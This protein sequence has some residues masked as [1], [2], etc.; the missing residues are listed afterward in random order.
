M[1]FEIEHTTLQVDREGGELLDTGLPEQ[2]E[3]SAR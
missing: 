3:R 2:H 1:R